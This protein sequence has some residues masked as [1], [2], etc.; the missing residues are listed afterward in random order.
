MEPLDYVR[1]L[2]TDTSFASDDINWIDTVKNGR[3][4]ISADDL[5]KVVNG[6]V[7]LELIKEIDKP[8]KN[9]TKEGGQFSFSYGLKREFVL[10]DTP[11]P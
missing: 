8:V 3:V 11:N 9:G 6:P 4:V 1:V 10:K 2:L 5:R 7:H